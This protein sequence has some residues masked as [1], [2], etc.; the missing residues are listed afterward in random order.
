VCRGREAQDRGELEVS[1][2]RCLV[3]VDIFQI[4][5]VK[6]IELDIVK[7]QS[8]AVLIYFIIR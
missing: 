4:A 2:N 8:V 6:A 5:P 7:I 1:V 3:G